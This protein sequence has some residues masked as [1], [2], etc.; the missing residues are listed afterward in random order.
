MRICLLTH[1][2]KEDNGG[3]VFARHLVE[4]FKKEW[5]AEVVVLTT[6]DSGFPSEKPILSPNTLKLLRVLPRIRRMIKE[7]D[8]VHALDAYPYGVIATLA[9]W[10]LKKKII[11]TAV[12]TG[13][14]Q[15]L[16]HPQW[17]F[18][19]LVVWSYKQANAITAIS[20]FT[21]NLILEY[22]PN[23]QVKV[24]TPGVEYEKF[25]GIK[26]NTNTIVRD[27]RG[28]EHA[29]HDLRPYLLSVGSIRWRKGYKRSIKAFARVHEEFPDMNYVIVGKRYSEKYYQELL[30]IIRDLNLEKSVIFL[31][32]VNAFDTLRALYEHAELFC[33]LS[34]TFGHDV[35]GF[36]IV[37]LEA[38]AA[39]LPVVGSKGNGIEDA[40]HV[41]KNGFL[42]DWQDKENELAEKIIMILRDKDLSLRMSKESLEWVKAF[43]WD[44]KIDE[45]G[46]L[47]RTLGI[48]Q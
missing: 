43:G 45:Y 27:S 29:L 39:G 9:A 14:I 46:K 23:L 5:G 33:L 28:K 48:M 7:C 25:D 42:V 8:I 35:E 37:F 20:R 21:R 10:G 34:Q 38:A 4:G 22:L 1:N 31:E 13:S 41:D 40:V 17:L 26:T 15:L 18:T 6:V 44:K 11:L 36:G 12:G 3:G 24:I 2:L 19:R 30:R 32:E 16:Y 47:Y